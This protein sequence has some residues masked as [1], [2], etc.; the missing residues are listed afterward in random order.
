VDDSLLPFFCSRYC[1]CQEFVVSLQRN[2][3]EL[4]GHDTRKGGGRVDSNMPISQPSAFLHVYFAQGI[5]HVTEKQY[6]CIVKIEK[7]NNTK[8]LKVLRISL[9]YSTFVS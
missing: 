3:R 8:M 4:Q 6:L 1:T 7:Q 2:S 9:I 5:A